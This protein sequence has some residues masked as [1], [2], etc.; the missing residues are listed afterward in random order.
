MNTETKTGAEGEGNKEGSPKPTESTG[1]TAD[2]GMISKG[3]Q[4]V[5]KADPENEKGGGTSASGSEI[6]RDVQR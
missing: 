1:S 5:P 3:T 6:K 2:R 4:S